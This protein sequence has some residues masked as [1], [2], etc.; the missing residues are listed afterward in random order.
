LPFLYKAKY[1]IAKKAL[2]RITPYWPQ[3]YVDGTMNIWICKPGARSRGKGITIMNKLENIMELLS[4]SNYRE[5]NWV[6]QK[7][8]EKPLLIYKTKFDM[9]QWFVVTDWAPLTIWF[10]K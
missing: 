1:D 10:A 8:I 2:Q 9:R 6:V 7:Y 5:S 4:Q 3:L